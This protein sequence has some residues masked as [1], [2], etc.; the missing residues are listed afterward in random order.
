MTGFAHVV[1]RWLQRLCDTLAIGVA[2]HGAVARLGYAFAGVGDHRH[3]PVERLDLHRDRAAKKT[4]AWQPLGAGPNA[5]PGGP[6]DEPE[7]G[8][9]VEMSSNSGSIC[10]QPNYCNIY[11]RPCACCGGSD[12]VC[13]SGSVRG[14]YWSGDCSGRMIWFIDCCAQVATACPASCPFCKNT[15]SGISW[16]GPAGPRYWCTLAED[17]GVGVSAPPTG[18]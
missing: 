9:L 6:H 11:G 5:G 18:S 4:D 8:A 3:L 13:P 15:P 1:D 17:K 12:T 7:V 10:A 2:P 14:Y 16:C